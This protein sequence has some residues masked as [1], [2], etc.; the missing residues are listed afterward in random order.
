MTLREQLAEALAWLGPDYQQAV[1]SVMTVIENR[2][3]GA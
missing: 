2:Q 1:E 3:E